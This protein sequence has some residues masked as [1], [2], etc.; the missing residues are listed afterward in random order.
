MIKTIYLGSSSNQKKS[1]VFWIQSEQ[2]KL[3]SF[4]HAQRKIKRCRWW[5]KIKI[6]SEQ[7]GPTWWTKG[8]SRQWKVNCLYARDSR[9]NLSERAAQ[10]FVWWPSHGL[11]F[12]AQAYML[13]PEVRRLV[14]VVL[15]DYKSSLGEIYLACLFQ[16]FTSR[17]MSTGNHRSLLPHK[18]SAIGHT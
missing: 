17:Q 6:T 3:Y 7:N 2:A 12:S 4:F 13:E 8:N 5:T 11:H 9:W 16:R 14:N 10:G 18:H 1:I 15:I